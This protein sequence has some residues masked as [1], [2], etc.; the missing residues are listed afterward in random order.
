M[1]Q[2]P[3]D[4]DALETLFRRV[5]ASQTDVWLLYATSNLVWNEPGGYAAF[6]D[7][8]VRAA[9]WDNTQR[10]W[11]TGAKARPGKMVYAD[12]YR[13]T[14]SGL[15][16][17]AVSSNVYDESGT[18]QG[19][20][21]GDVA[22]SFLN[23]LIE[24]EALLVPG[25]ESFII[26]KSGLFITNPDISFILTKDYF[27]EAGKEPYRAAVLSAPSFFVMDT[28]HLLYTTEIP[29]AGWILVSTIP[30]SVIFA[31]VN[32][33]LLIT[34]L[35]SIAILL[36]AG[37]I[38]SLSIFSFIICPIKKITQAAGL[39]ADMNVT[40][41]IT[42]DRTDEIGMIQDALLTIQ[43]H[44]Q[45][46]MRS[47]ATKE[48]EKNAAL[49][50]SLNSIV[51][52]S[53]E[54]LA[55][56]TRIMDSV[57]SK[58]TEQ[59]DAVTNTA[60]SIDSIT[61]DINTLNNTVG[62]QSLHISSIANSTQHLVTETAL[63]TTQLAEAYETAGALSASSLSGRQMLEKLSGELAQIVFKSEN[64]KQANEAITN[65][66][67]QTNILAMNAAIEASHAGESGRGFAV[68]AGEI[69][70]LAESSKKESES[71][72]A[73]IKRIMADIV[74]IRNASTKTVETMEKMFD[75][76]E[77][78][79]S[80]ISTVNT[81]IEKQTATRKTILESLEQ[82]LGM[83]EQI[84]FSSRAI[85]QSSD[86]IHG[87]IEHLKIASQEVSTSVLD[88]LQASDRI[89]ADL[90]PAKEIVRL[91]SDSAS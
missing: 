49:S 15:L 18:D 34:S 48:S 62:T 22:I 90:L 45:S 77:A 79:R 78:V 40:A 53:L 1:A 11:F 43:N 39:L 31:P 28:D 65:L 84:Q 66:A 23:K 2:A 51:Q 30:A 13:A 36:V 74:Q 37:L 32:R 52:R 8:V 87:T 86:L 70:K 57:Q 89:T 7:G 19:V 16:T 88:V 63:I 85:Y 44:L 55:L 12:P 3:V 60:G 4:T 21:S 69:R 76:V 73:A 61:A 24:D 6:S 17:I 80:A 33:A 81:T 91:P 71:I 25:Q 9:T 64:L 56:I 35:I 29:E 75:S 72:A 10:P 50:R 59:V 14:N 46:R 67:A 41:P 26:D 83:N 82:T 58:S 54:E 42:V 27:T 20:I 47:L 5:V 38:L 68:V